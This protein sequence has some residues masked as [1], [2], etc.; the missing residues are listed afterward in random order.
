MG[1]N[2]DNIIR[3]DIV[4]VVDKF[5]VRKLDK[6]HNLIKCWLAD[7]KQSAIVFACKEYLKAIKSGIPANITLAFFMAEIDFPIEYIDKKDKIG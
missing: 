2:I 7:D 6:R 4:R 1:V 3:F 5:L